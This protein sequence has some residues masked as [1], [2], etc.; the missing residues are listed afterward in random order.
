MPSQLRNG[1]VQ[2]MPHI[3]PL[4][5]G[6]EL[7]GV[8]HIR[9][10]LPQLLTLFWVLTSHP[11]ALLALQFAK[12]MLQVIVHMPLTQAPFAFGAPGHCA[13]V[14][15][16]QGCSST[17]PSQSSSSP[18]PQISPCGFGLFGVHM[19]GMPITQA[20]TVLWHTPTPQEIVPRPSS[21]MP[22]QL[23]STP[24]HTS[25]APGLMLALLS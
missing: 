2:E 14:V 20:G 4:Q 18:L 15:Q 9:P 19:F 13:P 7:G 3:A 22:S 21:T 5:V 10:Q 11:S 12:P 24:L 23:S 1:E 6:V 8:G 17:V 16:V 25:G